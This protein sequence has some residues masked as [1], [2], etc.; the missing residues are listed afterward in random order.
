[1]KN[2]PGNTL[3]VFVNIGKSTV[4]PLSPCCWSVTSLAGGAQGTKHC[5]SLGLFQIIPAVC[6]RKLPGRG[7]AGQ[8]LHLHPTCRSSALSTS[9]PG[10]QHEIVEDLGE[11]GWGL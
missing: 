7:A 1:M 3:R 10:P 4:M 5:A 8:D 9:P 2:T 6:V 11:R